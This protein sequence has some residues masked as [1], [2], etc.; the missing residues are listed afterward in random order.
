MIEI[1]VILILAGLLGWEK[2]QNR[3]ERAKMLNMIVGKDTTEIANL[4]MADKTKIDVSQP[5]EPDLVPEEQ[6]SD[7]DFQKYVLERRL[8]G[9]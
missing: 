2:H 8:D 9:R 6:I 3:I 5:K 4:E 7:E 1:A